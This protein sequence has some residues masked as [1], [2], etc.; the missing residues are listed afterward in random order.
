MGPGPSPC[1]GGR[2]LSHRGMRSQSSPLHHSEL[3]DLV[4]N[5]KN[6]GP[7]RI[8]LGALRLCSH[9]GDMDVMELKELVDRGK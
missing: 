6:V 1:P 2:V 4:C 5:L 3:E 7:L 8:S 9:I